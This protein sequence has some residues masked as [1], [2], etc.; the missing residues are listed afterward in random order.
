MKDYF[1][2][3]F[4]YDRY[5]N[6]IILDT[7]GKAN[8]PEKPVKLMAH[9]LAA[10]QVWLNRVKSL[11][12]PGGPLWPDSKAETLGPVIA[13]NARL[14]KDFLSE[15]NPGDFEKMI[16]Y[17]DFKGQEWENK[18]TDVLTHVI[19]HGTHHRAQAGQHLIAAGIEKLPVTDY[20]FF[21]R[22]M[23]HWQ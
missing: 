17:K 3:L 7:I 16:I 12:A 18:L 4:E 9:A 22:A 10:Q 2:R 15:Q 21:I 13:E 11:P 23:N 1:I 20:I 14:W 6:Q 8:N 19:N 5:A